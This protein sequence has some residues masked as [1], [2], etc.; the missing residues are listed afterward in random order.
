MRSHGVCELVTVVDW[1]TQ[2]SR[3]ARVAAFD[4][5]KM[6]MV[7]P[8]AR[9]IIGMSLGRGHSRKSE[10]T[11]RSGSRMRELSCPSATS[12]ICGIT[13]TQ[14]SSRAEDR[15][16]NN[17]QG[18]FCVQSHC[19]FNLSGP[20]THRGA[21]E[22]SRFPRR[23]LTIGVS[24]PVG[25]VHGYLIVSHCRAEQLPTVRQTMWGLI[26]AG[27]VVLGLTRRQRKEVHKGMGQHPA[28]SST[29]VGQASKSTLPGLAM[30]I[31]MISPVTTP[32]SSPTKV[33]DRPG[34][35]ENDIR[36]VS[37][38]SDPG[39]PDAASMI[40]EE[41]DCGERVDH[42]II[43]AE[44]WGSS[45]MWVDDKGTDIDLAVFCDA[46]VSSLGIFDYL[47]SARGS[48]L[49][50]RVKKDFL[51]H[52]ARILERCDAFGTSRMSEVLNHESAAGTAAMC[53]PSATDSLLW[54]KR[55]LQFNLLALRNVCAQAWSPQKS[56][57]RSI[58][59]LAYSQTLARC[60]N[61]WLRKM[62]G[63][64][65]CLMPE[66]DVEFVEKCLG[67]DTF[68]HGIDSILKFLAPATLVT[69]AIVDHYN[70]HGLEARECTLRVQSSSCSSCAVQREY[71]WFG[72]Y[73]EPQ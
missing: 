4:V 22:I 56:G 33:F 42:F 59:E 40:S 16:G 68:G 52:V 57:V 31:D 37:L 36:S 17:A 66:S 35:D 24:R 13:M 38:G 20:S 45:R 26:V 51:K 44:S 41:E 28:Q 23:F 67:Y 64:A 8:C 50:E 34:A 46:I 29:T 14:K 11:G 69:D 65:L 48:F 70:A 1:T 10:R 12:P 18:V 27:L 58:F 30:C 21:H 9:Y 72:G 32:P 15:K 19:T 63:A 6:A 43:M 61:F 5:T 3:A 54:L 39:T 55:N 49:K 53:E 25:A 7:R 73:I 60:Y 47:L 62:I 71:S 2:R